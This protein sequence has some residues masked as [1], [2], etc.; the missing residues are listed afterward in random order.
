MTLVTSLIILTSAAF[1]SLILYSVIKL[2]Y[3]I[4]EIESKISSHQ[5]SLTKQQNEI[6]NLLNTANS[7]LSRIADN[8]KLPSSKKEFKKNFV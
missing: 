8:K 7:Y 6:C 5:I 2:Y 3:R 4:L 1:Q